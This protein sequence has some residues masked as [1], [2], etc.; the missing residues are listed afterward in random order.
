MDISGLCGGG[1]VWTFEFSVFY[2][3]AFIYFN[4]VVF[5]GWGEVGLVIEMNILNTPKELVLLL[6]IMQLC[7]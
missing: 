1:G 5:G 7:K 3:L 4:F 6:C 2:L